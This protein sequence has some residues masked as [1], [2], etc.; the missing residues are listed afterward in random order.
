MKK[1]S[2]KPGI[3][4]LLLNQDLSVKIRGGEFLKLLRRKANK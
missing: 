2:V 3:K 1:T 4:F